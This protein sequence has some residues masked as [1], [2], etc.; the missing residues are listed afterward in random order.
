M[1][2]RNTITIATKN[3]LKSLRKYRDMYVPNMVIGNDDTYIQK[4][5]TRIIFYKIDVYDGFI[6]NHKNPGNLYIPKEVLYK[7]VLDKD[8]LSDEY[9][10]TFII[11]I[12]SKEINDTIVFENEID[13]RIFLS[14]FGNSIDISGEK[15]FDVLRAADKYN[16]LELIKL[17][18]S[19]FDVTEYCLAC[20]YESIQRL[21]YKNPIY[22]TAFCGNCCNYHTGVCFGKNMAFYFSANYKPNVKC[23][24]N[25]GGNLLRKD[26]SECEIHLEHNHDVPMN[27]NIFMTIKCLD[28]EKLKSPEMRMLELKIGPLKSIYHDFISKIV[29]ENPTET[30]TCTTEL[31]T[32]LIKKILPILKIWHDYTVLIDL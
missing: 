17:I 22:A 23:Q 32:F 6:I 12:Q 30:L 15:I 7:I 5:Y 26:I 8:V 25:C 2:A 31:A 20:L 18:S 19:N 10:N 11:D 3:Q 14:V 13:E 29:T 9:K 24:Y 27:K 16:L 4:F 1:Y 28:I 21:V